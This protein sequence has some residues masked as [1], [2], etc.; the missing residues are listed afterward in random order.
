[1][2]AARDGKLGFL[3]VTAIGVGGMVGG[4]I[5]AVLGLAVQL[6]RGSTPLAFA[7]GGAI[8]LVTGFSYARLAVRYPSRGG[9]VIF[10]D[11]VF[12]VDLVTGSLNNLLWASYVV[13][14]ALYAYAFGSYA[15]ALVGG[16]HAVLLHVL[17]SAGILGPAVLNLLDAEL[18]G[19]VETYIVVVKITVLVG[20]IAVGA[21]GVDAARLAPATWAP[22]SEIVAGGLII[23]VAYEGFELIT[24]AAEDVRDVKILP[25]ALYA[26]I[27]GVIVLYVL[28]SA[29]AVGS[30][31]VPQVVAAK[32][33]ALAAAAEPV[34]GRAGFAAISVAALLS[35]LSAINATLYGAGRL[36]YTIAREGELPAALERNVW[37]QPVEGLLITAA[38][39]L[40]LANLGDLSSISTLGSAGFLLVFAAVNAANARRADE[41]LHARLL[42]AVGALAC[43]GALVALVAHAATTDPS[44]LWLL[45]A[46]LGAP[47]LIELVFR[48]SGRGLRMP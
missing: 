26:S 36:S 47:T 8:A 23:F 28:I 32:E 9:T 4:G 41:R 1:V 46:L 42:S 24:N 30:L 20:F 45:A 44:S 31:P 3:A 37:R 27:A 19:R 10:L 34:L 17:I 25:R 5:F 11:R 14:L 38:L 33:Y 16:R 12:G 40:V 18:I 35:T 13:M 39:A 43:A 29:V 7:V 15:S 21:A 2:A 22:G 6:A 48:A